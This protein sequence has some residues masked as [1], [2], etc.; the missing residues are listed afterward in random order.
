VSHKK[1]LDDAQFKAKGVLRRNKKT[2]VFE[3]AR[4][5]FAFSLA[6]YFVDGILSMRKRVRPRDRDELEL[7]VR[8]LFKVVNRRRFRYVR[9]ILI[10][11][12]LLNVES[13]NINDVFV[14]IVTSGESDFKEKFQNS[15]NFAQ[16]FLLHFFYKKELIFDHLKG[17]NSTLVVEKLKKFLE[18]EKKKKM[19]T[20]TPQN[21]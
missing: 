19:K 10:D 1:V 6:K 2:G 11:Y 16:I 13:D 12:L 5:F 9:Q 4:E 14:Q 15:L 7:R 18:N 8:F 20:K 17:E 21:S 3:V